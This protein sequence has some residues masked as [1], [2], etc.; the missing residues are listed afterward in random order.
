MMPKAMMASLVPF[1][2]IEPALN[3]APTKARRHASGTNTYKLTAVTPSLLPSCFARAMSSSFHEV[4]W[5]LR[6]ACLVMERATALACR[7]AE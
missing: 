4:I 7:A 2:D 5:R 3:T 1:A 6:S